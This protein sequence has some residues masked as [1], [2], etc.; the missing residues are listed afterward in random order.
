MDSIRASAVAAPGLRLSS[1]SHWMSRV[2]P[3]SAAPRSARPVADYG[4]TRSTRPLEIGRPIRPSTPTNSASSSGPSRPLKSGLRTRQT[5]ISSLDSRATRDSKL[6]TTSESHQTPPRSRPR[7]NAMPI[8]TSPEEMSQFSASPPINSATMN[9]ALSALRSAGQRRRAMTAG[10]ED[11]E[12]E[13]QRS[14]EQEAERQLQK[15]IKDRVP[16][17]RARGKAK[18]GDIDGTSITSAIIA[19]CVVFTLHLPHSGAGSN[20]R[21]VGTMYIA[22]CKSHFLRQATCRTILRPSKV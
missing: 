13:R 4:D 21:R 7:P 3:Y 1:T 14:L 9:A 17:K 8:T 10:S 11:V 5:S 20:S 16:Q 19:Y 15:R 6:D 2:S 18:A 12:W 22:G